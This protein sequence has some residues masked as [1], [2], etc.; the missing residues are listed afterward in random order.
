LQAHLPVTF[1]SKVLFLYYSETN[2]THFLFS[3]LRIK[4]VY[5]FR[6]LLAHPQEA[7][8]KRHLVY[9]VRVMSVGCTRIDVFH[10]HAIYQV[11]LVERLLRISK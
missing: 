6:A 10:T 11:P 9:C 8:H 5:M 2:V 3:L 1:M 7:F 4:G